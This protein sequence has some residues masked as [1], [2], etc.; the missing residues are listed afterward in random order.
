MPAGLA[1]PSAGTMAIN[2]PLDKVFKKFRRPPC[3]DGFLLIGI[4]L[5]LIVTY[6]IFEVVRLR[7]WKLQSRAKSIIYFS[8]PKNSSGCHDVFVCLLAKIA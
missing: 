5:S 1:R 7:G 3:L 8:A 4:R 6:S 2:A